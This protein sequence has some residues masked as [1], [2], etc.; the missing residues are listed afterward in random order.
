MTAPLRGLFSKEDF[1]QIISGLSEAD[2][3]AVYRL[4]DKESLIFTTD[5]FTPVVDNPYDYG[6]IAAAN[7]LSDVYAM[8]G[9]V[10]M[11]LNIAGFPDKMPDAMIQEI[12]RGGGE[13]VRQAG[14]AIAGGHTIDSD[15]PLY[16]LAVLGRIES[17]KALEKSGAIPGDIIYLT[18]PVGAGIVT[19]AL[20]GEQ[21]EEAHIKAA[22]D[23]MKRLNLVA[24]RC[25]GSSRCHSSTD[26]TG[27]S[28]LGHG[29]EIARHSGVV[30]E[31][32]SESIPF[33]PGAVKYAREWLFPAGM[34]RNMSAFNAEVVFDDS[35]DEE[36]QR[37]M[38]T[39]ETSGGLLL[40][41]AREDSETFLDA[42]RRENQPVWKIGRVVDGEPGISIIRKGP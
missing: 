17:G 25:A 27:F 6:A 3:A 22:V 19:T 40:T 20:K 34:N 41:F 31:I 1:P 29:L 5:F 42:C 15:E 13:I 23:S 12:F 9:D 37:L 26:V 35:I 33:L 11:A 10:I 28:L 16:G 30:L 2:D 32:D 21:A 24:S 14:A 36:L 8:G 39:P 7:A 38:F 4:N 18:K